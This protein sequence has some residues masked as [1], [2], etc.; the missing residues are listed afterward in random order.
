MVMCM[1]LLFFFF[2][3]T[4]TRGYWARD[5]PAVLLIIM[6]FLAGICSGG[7]GCLGHVTSM[8]GACHMLVSS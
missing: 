1:N 4:A 6:G 8:L 3:L 5:D 7:G 2:H